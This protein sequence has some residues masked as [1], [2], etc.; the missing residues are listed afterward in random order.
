LKTNI[1]HTNRKL[2]LNVTP[3]TVS[4]QSMHL[5]F[6]FCPIEI[7]YIVIPSSKHTWEI[8][9][10]RLSDFSVF[11]KLIVRS[12]NLLS[13]LPRIE[14]FFTIKFTLGNLI[15]RPRSTLLDRGMAEFVFPNATFMDERFSFKACFCCKLN[16]PHNSTLGHIER[17]ERTERE[18]DDGLPLL[19]M[20]HKDMETLINTHEDKYTFLSCGEPNNEPPN[21]Q[22]L[23]MPFTKLSWALIFVTIFGWPLVLS[24]IENDFDLK[25]VLKDFDALFIGWAMILEQSHLRATNYKGRGPLYCY[26]GCVLLAILVLSNAYKGDNIKTLTKSFK[27]V[28]LTHIS[29]VIKAEYK[30]YG[31][32]IC[33]GAYAPGLLDKMNDI[34]GFDSC[35]SEFNSEVEISRVQHNEEQLKFWKPMSYKRKDNFG[36]PK[37]EL[38]F[39][40]Q[41]QKSALLDWRSVLEPLEKQLLKEHEKAKVYLGQEFLFND[42]TGWRLH[43]YVSIK[44]L[45]RMW[46]LVE[47]GIYNELRNISYK[48][49][50]GAVYEPQAIKID[51]N[52]FVQFVYHSAG[53][54]LAFLVFI[55]ELRNR[56]NLCFNAVRGICCFYLSNFLQQTQKAVLLAFRILV[57]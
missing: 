5:V 6:P 53:L 28:P 25:N 44:V 22:A 49:S 3:S 20:T 42:H 40:R 50:A 18:T 30:T 46:T 12:H 33:L 52:I 16:L 41:C 7:G 19:I 31:V 35:S 2:T 34:L 54:L 38:D 43:R 23:L 10:T 14:D 4:I 1:L 57:K 45:K 11:L 9:A 55:V 13:T 29:H 8:E 21:F 26:C 48:P 39:L 15:M 24:L 27:S 37:G 47:S 17:A 32:K 51:G 36:F 56:I